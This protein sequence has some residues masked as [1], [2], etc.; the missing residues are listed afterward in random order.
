[1][2]DAYFLIDS[3]SILRKVVKLKYTIKPAIVVMKK[4]TSLIIIEFHDAKR[5]QGMSHMINMIRCYFRLISMWRYVHQHIS[6]CRVCI[7]FL[8]NKIYTQPIH[9]EIPQVPFAG[10]T[11]DCIR[12]LPATSKGHMHAL[13]FICLLTSC[14]ITV[15]L[16]TK[17]ADEVSVAY[18]KDILPKTSCPK[19]ILQD[20]DTEFRNEQLLTIFDSL[21]IKCI[22]SYPYYP[23]GNSRIGN[24]HNFLK[25]TIAK[26]R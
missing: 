21:G 23:K 3:N 26:F 8:A 1:M 6:T 12:P 18:M 11:I 14:L 15:S 17:T 22:Y 5:H 19:L 20:N 13:T 25:Y 2:P 10:C 24:V 16:K 4:L 9:L 7:Q